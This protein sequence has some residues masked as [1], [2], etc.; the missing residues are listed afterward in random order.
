MPLC[1]GLSF[2][3]NADPAHIVG[4]VLYVTAA[5]IVFLAEAAADGDK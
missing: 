1:R 5:A 4:Y 2:A 3:K